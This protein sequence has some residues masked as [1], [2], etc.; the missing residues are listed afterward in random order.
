MDK[1]ITTPIIR[2]SKQASKKQ[3]DRK[4]N[5]P[6][7]GS[8]AGP[9]LKL[10][11]WSYPVVPSPCCGSPNQGVV[12]PPKRGQTGQKW[13]WT[14]PRG[15]RR[16]RSTLLCTLRR[17]FGSIF[18]CF[19]AVR[20]A[21][22]RN[23]KMAVSRAGRP[24]SRFRWHFFLVQLPSLGGFHPLSCLSCVPRTLMRTRA[25]IVTQGQVIL[26]SRRTLGLTQKVS[27]TLLSLRDL[28]LSVLLSL[29]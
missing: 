17:P 4:E 29:P 22:R 20:Q 13:P 2:T 14:A 26:S 10:W 18:A 6:S 3:H 5:S 25:C 9:G 21:R 16:A 19:G 24:E 1:R 8:G 12:P 27:P 28:L 7:S 23:R 15:P 11:G